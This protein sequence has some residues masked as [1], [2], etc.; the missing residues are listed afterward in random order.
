MK[1]FNQQRLLVIGLLASL[2]LNMFFAGLTISHLRPP[3]PFDPLHMLSRLADQLPPTDAAILRQVL[4]SK[5]AEMREDEAHF[6]SF[7]QRLDAALLAEPFDPAAL[8]AVFA[9]GRGQESA[10]SAVMIEAATRM[11]PEGRHRLAMARP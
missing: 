9:D 8:A 3:P 4:D 5:A 1:V 2:G 7:P 6:R 11:S 10:M